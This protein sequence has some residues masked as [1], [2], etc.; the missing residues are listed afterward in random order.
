[1]ND[2]PGSEEALVK[3]RNT[4][5]EIDVNLSKMATE[6]DC[7][8]KFMLILEDNSFEMNPDLIEKFW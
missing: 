7:I 3:L 4:I 5:A 1:L 2:A 8:Y 6:V